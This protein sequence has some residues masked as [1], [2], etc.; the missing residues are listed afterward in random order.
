MNG[1][2][3]ICKYNKK[4][5]NNIEIVC[6]NILLEYVNNQ[7]K[8]DIFIQVKPAKQNMDRKTFKNLN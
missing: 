5:H 8:C 2:H 4:K 7:T 6:Q 1:W 3:C